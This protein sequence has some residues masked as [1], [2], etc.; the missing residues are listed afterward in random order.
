MIGNNFDRAQQ[1]VGALGVLRGAVEG[2]P[3]PRE[4]ASKFCTPTC[5]IDKANDIK[6]SKYSLSSRLIWLYDK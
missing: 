2:V 5:G 1:D 4:H 6:K 3:A